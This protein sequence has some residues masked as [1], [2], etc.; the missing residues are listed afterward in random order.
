MLLL[1]ALDRAQQASEKVGSH[2]VVVDPL[3]EN[4]RRFYEKYGFVALAGDASRLYL[5]M[6]T[7]AKLKL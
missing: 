4:A 3:S 1:S 7:I 5:P 6:A 2:A